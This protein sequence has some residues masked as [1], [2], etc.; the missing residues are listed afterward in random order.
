M[1]KLLLAEEINPRL[2]FGANLGFGRQVGGEHETAYELNAALSYVV[3]D[4]KLAVGV[5]A[6]VEYE[7]VQGGGDDDDGPTHSTTIMVGPSVL[8]KPTPSTHVGLVTLFG[9]TNDSPV[10]Q[11]FILFGMDFEP[12]SGAR[13]ARRGDDKDAGLFQP[14]HRPR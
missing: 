5:E 10:M 9:L 4:S 12:F 11:A 7:S 8:Y 2:H 6:L 13:T 14:V 3:K 1:F